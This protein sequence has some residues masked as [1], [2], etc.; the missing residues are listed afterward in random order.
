MDL[1][2]PCRKKSSPCGGFTG[3]IAGKP[4]P[5]GSALV[6]RLALYL[7]EILWF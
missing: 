5:T 1:A 3:L 7:W 6:Q 2:G 4:A